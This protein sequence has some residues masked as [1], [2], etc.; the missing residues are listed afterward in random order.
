MSS[1]SASYLCNLRNWT[2]SKSHLRSLRLANFFASRSPGKAWQKFGTKTAPRPTSRN[3]FS[4]KG[5][6][7]AETLGCHWHLQTECRRTRNTRARL[8][9][10]KRICNGPTQEL[11]LPVQIWSCSCKNWS[12]N[13]KHLRMFVCCW[14]PLGS[15]FLKQGTATV[16][17]EVE[18]SEKICRSSAIPIRKKQ[19][20]WTWLTNEL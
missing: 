11:V 9:Y 6:G 8:G 12:R 5:N 19:A 13:T 17:L 7:G 10:V 4:T 2:P 18:R 20:T 15:P 3:F 1:A 14:V 16:L